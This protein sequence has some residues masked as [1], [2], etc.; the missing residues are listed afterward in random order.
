MSGTHYTEDSG[1]E[2]DPRE[3]ET[4]D[5]GRKRVGFSSDPKGKQVVRRGTTRSPSPL[6]IDDETFREMLEDVLEGI[7]KQDKWIGKAAEEVGLALEG[8]TEDQQR[9][10]HAMAMI[11]QE[12]EQSGRLAHSHI[13]RWQDDLE[14]LS[15]HLHDH[16]LARDIQ[17]K[18]E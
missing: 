16:Q 6:K 12:A 18:A 15:N 14:D 7:K 10:W 5:R 13:K 4:E 8:L 1:E 17:L 9:T 3:S 2:I 11:R